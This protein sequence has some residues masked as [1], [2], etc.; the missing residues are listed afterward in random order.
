MAIPDGYWTTGLLATVDRMN[1]TLMQFDIAAN[2]PASSSTQKGMMFYATDTGVF[3]YDNGSSWVTID[4]TVLA[5]KVTAE[6]RT[7]AAASG[8]VS[9]T[10]AGF[11]PTGVIILGEGS[12]GN[13]S[14]SIGLGTGAVSGGEMEIHTMGGTPVITQ[15]TSGNVIFVQDSTGS[16]KQ[17]A[18][19]KTFDS[20]GMTLTWTKTVNGEACNFIVM[21][22]R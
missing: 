8:D 21:Y 22:L 1:Q 14:L 2:R 12:D 4:D 3:S 7:A 6:S 15:F 10:G 19:L 16:D 13:D 5:T 11:L 9:Y 17:A 20:D 18:V